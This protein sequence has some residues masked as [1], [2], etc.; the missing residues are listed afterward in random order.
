MH[1]DGTFPDGVNVRHVQA[2]MTKNQI[3][4]LIGPPQFHE[5]MWGVREW[6]YVFHFRTSDSRAAAVCQYKVLFDTHKLARSFYW[7][8]ASCAD[9]V[10]VDAKVNPLD[11]AVPQQLTL[12]SDALF[13]FNRSSV[14]SLASG[15]REKLDALAA[16]VVQ[17]GDH[18]TRVQVLGY[19][20]PL[21]SDVYDNTLSNKRAY[22]V[23][24]YLV[25]QGV[26]AGRIT[27]A[28]L[29]SSDL[30]RTDCHQSERKAL[31]ACLKPN[32]RVEIQVF[33]KK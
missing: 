2:G 25:K 23:L 6:D 1:K 21:G 14:D 12:S 31:I 20:D 24:K 26:P 8:P 18:V 29:G 15:G 9:F 28:G 17:R 27:A 22:A 33:G 19:T 5:G 30:V 13:G 32:R 10:K 4:A 11:K 3:I 16:K 7:K